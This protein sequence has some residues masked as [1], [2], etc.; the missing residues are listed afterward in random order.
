MT[1]SRLYVLGGLLALI[2]LLAAFILVDVLATVFFA[3]T[4]AYLL[5]PLRRRLE[6]RGISRWG[7]SAVATVVAAVGVVVVLAPL[8]VILFLRLDDLFALASLLP[9][10][11]SFEFLDMFYEVTLNEVLT[12]VFSLIRSLGRSAAT[13]A[14]VVLIKLTLFGFLV[15]SLVLGGDSVGRTLLASVPMEYHDVARAL[16][17]RAR[18]TLFAIYVLQAAT[19]VG[20]FFIALVVFWGLG[21][22]YVITLSTVAAIL[23]FIPIVG[24][25]FLLALLAL[26]HVAVGNVVAAALIVVVGGFAIAWLPDVL[27]RPRLAK[28]TADLPGSLYFVGFVGGLLS[29]GPVGIIAG[30][31]VVALLAEMVSILGDELNVEEDG[32]MVDD[33]APRDGPQHSDP[34]VGSGVGTDTDSDETAGVAH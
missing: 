8:F 34:E 31:L 24:P 28:E 18:E 14:P 7:A 12:V 2:S 19:A 26:Y 16:N 25:S 3:I 30:P 22:D 21:Y 32:P 17:T 5:I 1:S 15:F 4:V 9:E 10:A 11:L 20:T 6:A 13:A 33:S 23:Q 27:I 29:L